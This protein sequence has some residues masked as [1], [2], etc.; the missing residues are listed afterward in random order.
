MSLE[1]QKDAIERFAAQNDI[2]ITKWFQE[3]QTAAKRGRPVFT[4]MLATL[5]R[6]GADG[7]IMHRIDRSARNFF[8][9]AKLG[10]LA[11]LGIEVHFASESLDFSSRG[12]RLA[13]NV[14][15]AVA[16]DYCRNLSIEAKKGLLGRMKQGIYPF[17]APIGYLN[18]G[19]GQLKTHDP[20]RAPLIRRAF[21][22]YDAGEHSI[23]SLVPEMTRLGLRSRAGRPISRRCIENIL[24][25]P[26]YCG[27]IR[28]KRSGEVF[29]GAHEPI[30]SAELFEAVQRRKSG[31]AQKKST[32]HNYTYRGLFRCE[33]CRG[34]MTPEKQKGHVYYRCHSPECPTT[35]VR[36]EALETKI[37]AILNTLRLSDEHIAVLGARVDE[38]CARGAD[39]ET[40]RLY[41]MQLKQIDERLE[42]LDDAA[43]DQI[44]DKE[45]HGRRKQALLLERTKIKDAQERI[46]N[47][48][49]QPNMLRGFFERLK[50]LA[51]H[52]RFAPP[53]EK[54]QITELT[55]SNRLVN[56]KNVLVEPSKWLLACQNALAVPCGGPDGCTSRKRSELR[57]QQLE[58]LSE[59]IDLN[60]VER[61]ESKSQ[62]DKGLYET[63]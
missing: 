24:Q 49:R 19:S 47:L 3:K 18:N 11:D 40:A 61:L 4:N 48:R 34:A 50:T 12:G 30:I 14:Q 38:L 57:D 29:P 21:E 13:A 46:S 28:M 6:R 20:K 52:Y 51:E 22:L 26:F 1:A 56:R 42:K 9:W 44:I 32:F 59:L 58:A 60:I 41:A 5:K 16:E 31:K 43:I 35:G 25:N 27:L 37:E 10:E 8:D 23:N 2:T 55:T 62:V 45:T 15:M 39:P 53:S 63:H 36:E 54:R 17:N 7:V 33:V